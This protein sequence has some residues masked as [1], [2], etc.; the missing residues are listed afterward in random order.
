[1]KSESP[2]ARPRTYV[3]EPLA[4]FYIH[5]SFRKLIVLIVFPEHLVM[6]GLSYSSH[7]SSNTGTGCRGLTPC[8]KSLVHFH[9]YLVG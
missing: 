1:M 9:S 7:N 8:M 2:E 5:L 3:Y 4:D 6:I